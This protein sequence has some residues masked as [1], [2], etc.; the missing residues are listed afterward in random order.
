MSSIPKPDSSKNIFQLPDINAKYSSTVVSKVV[1]IT[2]GVITLLFVIAL[3]IVITVKIDVTIDA[4][5]QLEPTNL[6]Y[7]N[8]P[9]NGEIKKIFVKGGD[10]FKKGGPLV[11][12]DS[13]K[14]CDQV[15][16][17]VRDMSIKKINYEM[18]IK[19]IPYEKTQNVI[20]IKKAEA[21]LLKAKANLRQKMGDYF[22]GVNADSFL[23][24]YKKGTHITLDYALAEIISAEAE[25]ENLNSKQEVIDLKN[26]E[27][28][29]LML[30]IK[31]LDKT[32]ERQKE[33]LKK[34]K[35]L[36]PFDGIILTEDLQRLEGTFATEGAPI[37][38]IS[39]SNTWKAILNVGEKDVYEL[40]IGDSVKIEIKAMKQSEEFLLFPG[41]VILVSAEPIKD[42]LSQA[43]NGYYKV[44]VAINLKDAEKYLR[45]F[46]RGFSIKAKIVKDTDRIINILVKN[47]R[48]LL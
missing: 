26:L 14:L 16:K 33:Y 1:S 4:E 38:E 32:I 23:V 30:E 10:V 35:L 31:Q 48:K 6:F 19:S 42:R 11:Q 25:L 29:S 28:K 43:S 24:S 9:L 40:A 45:K 8:S 12:F 2:F 18:K 41:K 21:Q 47:I 37:L 44:E 36:A 20:Q 5:G 46:K 27:L 15:E 22:P 3:L 13:V 34:T 17:L 39:Q 7:V